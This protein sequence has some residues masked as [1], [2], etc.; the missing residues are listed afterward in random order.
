MSAA[1]SSQTTQNAIAAG[2]KLIAPAVQRLLAHPKAPRHLRP[3]LFLP[4]QRQHS[5]AT[6]LHAAR[7]AGRAET[8]GA[9][10][11]VTNVSG[12]EFDEA[13]LRSFAG[14]G[15]KFKVFLLSA[16]SVREIAIQT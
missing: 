1:T 9:R 15:G 7:E 10:V 3:R 16:P 11:A 12:E 8:C 13:E 14:G 5:L 4:Q 6:L 2:Q